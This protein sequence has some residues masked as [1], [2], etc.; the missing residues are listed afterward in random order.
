MIVVG[1]L[2]LL[3]EAVTGFLALDLFFR[4]TPIDRLTSQRRSV[5]VTYGLL[6]F[7]VCLA[8]AAL[9]WQFGGGVA[10]ALSLPGLPIWLALWHFGWLKQFP[11]PDRLGGEPKE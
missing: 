4:W 10:L 6:G 7:A 9:G 3:A 11:D 5:A 2:V 1:I 8:A